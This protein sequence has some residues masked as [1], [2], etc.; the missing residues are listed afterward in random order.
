MD[1]D[2]D[3]EALLERSSLGS[4]GARQLRA[5]TTPERADNIRRIIELLSLAERPD[6]TAAERENAA[7]KLVGLAHSIGN[8][9]WWYRLAD[10]VG[11]VH[12]LTEL[13]EL[14]E[15]A[16]DLPGAVTLYMAAA[17]ASHASVS[18]KLAT[19]TKMREKVEDF[20]YVAV[21]NR[22]AI[23]VLR[24]DAAAR[25]EPRDIQ[26]SKITFYLYH[27]QQ[28]GVYA[29]VLQLARHPEDVY[30]VM[31]NLPED[32]L[33]AVQNWLRTTSQE[34]DGGEEAIQELVS[35]RRLAAGVVKAILNIKSFNEHVHH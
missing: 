4:K 24:A 11:H 31:E 21:L 14:L 34:A 35:P 19:L 30:L 1:D 2:Q 6:L 15:E 3:F 5:R 29:M 25:K 28:G 12:T 20:E 33:N 17:D 22:A 8:P 32:Q 16:G 9:Q 26:A 18:A 13:S 27:L 7:R 10:A 23:D